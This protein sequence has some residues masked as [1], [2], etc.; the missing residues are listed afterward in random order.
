MHELTGTFLCQILERHKCRMTYIVHANPKGI[1][2]FIVNLFVD[3]NPYET[4][5]GIKRMVKKPL[6]TERGKKSRY[7]PFIEKFF[8]AKNEKTIKE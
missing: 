7:L 5:Q 8:A 1:P 3:D 6:Y 2:G 4:L